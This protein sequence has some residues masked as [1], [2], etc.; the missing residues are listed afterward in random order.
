MDKKLEG[1]FKLV[2]LL[3][4]FLLLM[5]FAFSLLLRLLI[6]LLTV[7]GVATLTLFLS[8]FVQNY[9]RYGSVEKAFSKS[10]KDLKKLY[11]LILK[12]AFGG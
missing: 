12:K 5:F 7:L 4:I 9:G 8:M 1:Y 3:I 11:G 6:F 10:F 2:A